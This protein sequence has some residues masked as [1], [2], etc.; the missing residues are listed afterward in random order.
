MRLHEFKVNLRYKIVDN[1]EIRKLC[2]VIGSC[3]GIELKLMQDTIGF[4][5]VTVGSRL[6]RKLQLNNLGDIPARFHWDLTFCKSVFTIRPVKGVIPAHEDLFFDISFHPKAKGEEIRFPNVKC[7]IKDSKP[8]FVN[9]LGKSIMPTEESIKTVDFET[10]V[11][12]PI[13]RE[14]EVPNPLKKLWRIKANISSSLASQA[15]Y[16]FGDETLEI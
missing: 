4:G 5:V 9:L 10:I 13:Q 15:G 14:I 7:N 6:T 3:H 16:F 2:S 12:E 1:Q 8:L 11:R